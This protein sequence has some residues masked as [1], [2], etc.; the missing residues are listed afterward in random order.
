MPTSLFR[1]TDKR[2]PNGSAM[3]YVTN[4]LDIENCVVFYSAVRDLKERL[5]FVGIELLVKGVDLLKPV[6]F[7]NL[8]Q[9]ILC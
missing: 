5:M 9:L 6:S 7:E 3:K 8:Q 1:N 2:R 4:F